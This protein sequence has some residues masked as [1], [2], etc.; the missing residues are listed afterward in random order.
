MFVG[1]VECFVHG[2]TRM[3]DNDHHLYDM[4]KLSDLQKS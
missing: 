1:W 4:L 3:E 2:V